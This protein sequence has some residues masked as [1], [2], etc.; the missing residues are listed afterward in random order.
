MLHRKAAY[1]HAVDTI[2]SGGELV[3]PRDVVGG[4]GRQHLDLGVTAEMFGDV[5][6]VELGSAVDRLAVALD[7]DREL[8]CGSSGPERAGGTESR[9]A[10]SSSPEPWSGSSGPES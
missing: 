3:A 7:N 6:R 2:A 4:A 10:G 8:H 9:G 1:R 5:P